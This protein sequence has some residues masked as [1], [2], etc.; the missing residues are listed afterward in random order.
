IAAG[1]GG[2]AGGGPARWL[3]EASR[4]F[5]AR[6]G[7]LALSYDPALGEAFHAALAAQPQPDLWPLFAALA[8]L[9][10]ALVRGAGSDLLSEATA[11]E[12]ARRH[13]GLIRAEVPGR[14]HVPFLDEPAA[15]DAIRAW[16]L[17]VARAEAGDADPGR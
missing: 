13:P 7:G 3:T 10:V 2:F 16:L 11:A 15:V 8:G 1:A 5:V 14:G 6:E 9:P 17:A 12:M 4:R